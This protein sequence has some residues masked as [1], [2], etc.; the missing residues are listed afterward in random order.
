MI[1]AWSGVFSIIANIHQVC[2]YLVI[3]DEPK[4]PPSKARALASQ[5][6]AKKQDFVSS[7][8]IYARSI[9]VLLKDIPYLLLLI[10]YG[11]LC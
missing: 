6:E 4:H 10:S 7:C 8:K 1:L 5:A 2:V 3:R 9:G 11:M